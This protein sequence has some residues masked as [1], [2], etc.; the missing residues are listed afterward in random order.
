MEDGNKSAF[1]NFHALGAYTEDGHGTGGFYQ[2]RQHEDPLEILSELRG[3][4]LLIE[5]VVQSRLRLVG[6]LMAH[7]LNDEGRESHDAQPAELDQ[8]HDDRLSKAAVV[9]TGVDDHQAGDAD[10]RGCGEKGVERADSRRSLRDRQAQQNR[11][12]QDQARKGARQKS[13]RTIEEPA[14]ES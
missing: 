10:G 14:E 7:D 2:E 1:T 8:D 12:D 5:N 3:R 9:L 13:L 6:D 11:A 4:A